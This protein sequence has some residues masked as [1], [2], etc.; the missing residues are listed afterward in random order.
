MEIKQ[1]N[2]GQIQI[3]ELIGR[4]D[5]PNNSKIEDFFAKLTENLES[6]IVV[7]CNN[8]DFIN[9]SGLRVF[10]MSLKKSKAA[11]KQILLCNLQKNIKEV[12]QYSGFDNLF[13]INLNKEE[14][15]EKIS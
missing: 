11:N 10:I 5:A 9:S 15:L 14:A 8:L 6:N 2:I 1:T 7:D 13:N 4:I 12:F 3:V